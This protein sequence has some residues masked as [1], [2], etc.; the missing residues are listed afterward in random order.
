MPNRLKKCGTKQ[1][2]NSKTLLE[3]FTSQ[4]DNFLKV[5]EN[6]ASTLLSAR[7]P[8]QC[9]DRMRTS[10]KLSHCH[11]G[12]NTTQRLILGFQG[13]HE[14][15]AIQ[16]KGAGKLGDNYQHKLIQISQRR[17][18]APRLDHTKM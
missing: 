9:T 12:P 8:N 11:N 5:K 2:K 3:Y 15:L 14:A 7:S 1:L 4:A 10:C 13:G 18:N 17:A 6:S 16:S